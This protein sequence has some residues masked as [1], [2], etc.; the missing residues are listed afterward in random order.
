MFVVSFPDPSVIFSIEAKFLSSPSTPTDAPEDDDG[1]GGASGA[2]IGLAVIDSEAV[3]IALDGQY[4]LPDVIDLRV[5]VS[6]YFP[7]LAMDTYVRIGADGFENRAG[8]PVTA[9][10]LP[11]TLAAKVWSYL[12]VEG[13]RLPNLGGDP[14]FT[15]EGFCVG[16]GAGW[17]VEWDAGPVS[18]RASAKVLVGLGTKPFMLVGGIFV[19]GELSVAFVSIGASADLVITLQDRNVSIEGELRATLDLGFFERDVR[20]PISIG[21]SV[22][23]DAPPPPPPLLKVSLTDRNGFAIQQMD[24]GRTAADA[25]VWPDTVPVL[26]FAHPLACALP[27]DSRVRPR[28][29]T[30]RTGMER[31][32]QAQVRLPAQRRATRDRW[33]SARWRARLGVVVEH[34]PDRH[35]RRGRSAPVGRGGPVAGPAHVG[36]PGLVEASGPRQHGLTWRSVDHGVAALRPGPPAHAGVCVRNRRGPRRHLARRDPRRLVDVNAAESV[37]LAGAASTSASSTCRMPSPSRPVGA[38]RC[39]RDGPSRSLRSW[40]CLSFPTMQV[41]ST[42][43]PR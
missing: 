11:T 40:P 27:D 4:S 29:G 15:F 3:V 41:A 21:P 32:V 30:G 18:L 20:V 26:E 24:A 14:R 37:R 42:R 31:H 17:S 28:S 1:G 35:R 34:V 8:D 10:L 38:G 43:S 16:F 19:E 25:P 6:A 5:P 2:I 36:P 33:C 22:S 9:T 39:N 13:G 7:G 23:E 12:M